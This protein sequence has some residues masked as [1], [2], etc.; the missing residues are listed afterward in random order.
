MKKHTFDFSS[1]LPGGTLKDFQSIG[2]IERPKSFHTHEQVVDIASPEYWRN[3]ATYFSRP[4]HDDRITSRIMMLEATKAEMN[5]HL[6]ISKER[7]GD[8]LAFTG[9]NRMLCPK[10]LNELL[11]YKPKEM[12][13]FK[14]NQLAVH[15]DI[16]ELL[17][18]EKELKAL[19]YENT[20]DRGDV[21]DYRG[22]KDP[23]EDRLDDRIREIRD[24]Q[25]IATF[26]TIG[27]HY[28]ANKPGQY[29]PAR[30]NG[31]ADLHGCLFILPQDFDKALKIASELQPLFT[32]QDGVHIYDTDTRIFGVKALDNSEV[33]FY[34]KEKIYRDHV[35]IDTNYSNQIS[36]KYKWF[37]SSIAGKKYVDKTVPVFTTE[38]GVPKFAGDTV[39]YVRPNFVYHYWRTGIKADNLLENSLKQG[40][41]FFSTEE[42]CVEYIKRNKPYFNLSQNEMQE[43]L[44]EF[45]KPLGLS[46][47]VEALEFPKDFVKRD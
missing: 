14:N 6:G 10:S 16:I 30:N 17:K 25:K 4:T 39:W 7:M 12:K 29:T 42:G 28:C 22:D 32:T 5:K 41:K 40:Y 38:D 23:Y 15:G 45:L 35:I 19:G 21:F 18:F 20:S 47:T 26:I 36:S 44:N 13:R 34:P 37:S 2:R 31:N 46:T 27:L 1:L 9:I 3:A 33:N 8:S 11:N 43:F 24:V